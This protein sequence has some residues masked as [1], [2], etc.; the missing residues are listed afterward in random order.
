MG[1]GHEIFNRPLC[2]TDYASRITFQENAAVVPF[3]KT[4]GMLFQQ[5]PIRKSLGLAGGLKGKYS[6]ND[7][8]I[9]AFNANGKV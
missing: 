5:A 3:E 9:L 7:L 6:S 1:L 2:F 4:Q 8:F